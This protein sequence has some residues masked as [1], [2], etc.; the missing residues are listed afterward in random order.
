MKVLNPSST[1]NTT[2]APRPPSPP[3]GPP[4]GTY[5]SLLNATNPFPPSPDRTNIFTSSKN[6]KISYKILFIFLKI[7]LDK[8]S[9]TMNYYNIIFPTIIIFSEILNKK[10]YGCIH[11]RT[12][13]HRQDSNLRP[14]D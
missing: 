2:L 3:A 1:I 11:S 12:L 14:S 5:F 8:S 7:Q 6:I 4:F 13:L 9:Y 10:I